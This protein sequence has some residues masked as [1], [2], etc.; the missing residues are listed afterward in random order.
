MLFRDNLSS[1][2]SGPYLGSVQGPSFI[3]FRQ[4]LS[5]SHNKR[6]NS[7]AQEYSSPSFCPRISL[8]FRSLLSC[9]A[10]HLRG[11]H[12]ILDIFQEAC[13]IRKELPE[14]KRECQTHAHTISKL[15]FCY[16]LQVT[17]FH[18]QS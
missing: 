13:D 11:D 7:L 5:I 12:K 4:C 14:E 2:L 10:A 3:L 16:L 8:G 18:S 15:G 17:T 1:S 9:D 6:A